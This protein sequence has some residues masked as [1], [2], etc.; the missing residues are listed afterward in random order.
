M[1]GFEEIKEIDYLQ[2]NTMC[3]C[4]DYMPERVENENF[5]EFEQ[6]YLK[7]RINDF[8]EKIIDF[9]LKSIQYFTTKI[10]VTD[11]LEVE[12]EIIEPGVDIRNMSLE[13]LEKVISK[14]IINDKSSMQIL[15]KEDEYSLVSVNGEFSVDIYNP[16]PKVFNIC[17]K[18]IS[19]EGLFI[20]KAFQ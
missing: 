3:Y 18:L 10:F 13:K 20:R 11:A 19:Q 7:R 17:D 15:I 6:Y 16:T 9:V 5:Y 2:Q 14:I 8:S 12:G 1:D 4:V